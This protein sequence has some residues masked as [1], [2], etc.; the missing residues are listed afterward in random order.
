METTRTSL[1][2]RVKDREDSQ[3]W[4]EFVG[5]YRPI[6]LRYA[7]AWGLNHVDAEDMAQ[8]C[9]TTITEKIASFEYD[10]SRG[11][12][13]AWLR[14]MVNNRI[15]NMHARHRE[16]VADSGDF[17]RPQERERS[18]EEA[19]DQIWQEEHLKYCLEQIRAL[20]EPKT[21]EAFRRVAIEQAPVPEVCEALGMTANQVYVAR[22]RLTR[23]L[24]EMMTEMLA[25]VE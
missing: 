21:F 4:W 24:R 25:G 11:R 7:R 14:T 10:P 20:V 1:L 18:P 13:R 16:Q 5:L 17:K 8:Q 23:Q 12:F 15:Q 19:W 3:A 9:L 6:L 2:A 22:S